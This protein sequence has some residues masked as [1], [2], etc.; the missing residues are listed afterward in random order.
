MK[1]YNDELL[2]KREGRQNQ[3][4]YT[5]QRPSGELEYDVFREVVSSSLF[6]GESV[7]KDKKDISTQTNLTTSQE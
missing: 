2:E 4:G 7:D 6:E 3:S 5:H 1:Y